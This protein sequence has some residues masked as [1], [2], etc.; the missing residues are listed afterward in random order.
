MKNNLKRNLISIFEHKKDSVLFFIV[1]FVLSTFMII[2]LASYKIS[3]KMSDVIKDN[4]IIDFTVEEGFVNVEDFKY[5]QEY[6]DENKLQFTSYINQLKR[7]KE[8]IDSLNIDNSTFYFKANIDNYNLKSINKDLFEKDEYYISEGR[9]FDDYEIK[10]NTYLA[11]AYEDFHYEV[12]GEYKE[13]ALNDKIK[14]ADKEFEIVGFFKKDK[15]YQMLKNNSHY[16][17]TD[18]I[19]TSNTLLDIATIDS[20]LTC[21]VFSF[22]VTGVDSFKQ[23]SETL[24]KALGKIKIKDGFNPYKVSYDDSMLEKL[25]KPIAT[26][27]LFL[28]VISIF[29]AIIMFVLL[30][31]FLLCVISA[32]KNEFNIYMI[33]GQSKLKTSLNFLNEVL[34]ISLLAFIL[35]TP[36]AYKTSDY[37]SNSLI[38]A[39]L[40][41]Q[42]RIAVISKNEEEI[43]IFTASKKAYEDYTLQLNTSDYALVFMCEIFLISFSCLSIGLTKK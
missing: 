40:Q 29:M 3:N 43:D 20:K 32:R 36:V 26:L 38:D 11:L 27:K 8:T 10:E 5:L 33:L 31:S 9:F 37:L 30:T 25:E 16:E 23:V 6:L 41:R 42:R 34:L 19:L 12:N 7:L 1:I 13:C 14:I 28:Q 21:P 2:Y 35:S 4:V 18:L 24:N 17:D 15:A 39:N 22:T